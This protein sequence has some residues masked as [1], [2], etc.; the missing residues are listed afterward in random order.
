MKKWSDGGLGE[1]WGGLGV[2][3]AP[4]GAFEFTYDFS[5]DLVLLDIRKSIIQHL[6]NFL[7][8]EM[9]LTKTIGT[10]SIEH[11]PSASN[12]FKTIIF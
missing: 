9:G 5:P 2:P 11:L 7:V 12:N 10:A 3:G 1:N 6:W 8:T 4:H